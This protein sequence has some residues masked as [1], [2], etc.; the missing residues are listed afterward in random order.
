V[1][2]QFTDGDS[3]G[4][5]ST[6]VYLPKP[7]THGDIFLVFSHWD[8]TGITATISGGAGNTYVPLGPPIDIGTDAQGHPSWIQAWYAKIVSYTGS[9]TATYSATTDGFSLVDV[10]EYS[11]LDQ[12]APLDTASYA[13]NTGS[14]TS[15]LTTGASGTTTAQYET[16][17]GMFGVVDYG[18]YPFSPGSGF[19]E[20]LT[21]AS[22]YI[23][24][25]AATNT[26][27]YTAT[28]T[29]SGTKNYGAIIVG[30]KN[31]VQ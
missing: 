25:M 21:D 22:S 8:G 7:P 24:D 16:I 14:G 9:I 26:G 13:T 18:D 28:A 4:A 20:Q 11:G 12:T 23:E 3:N 30:F 17:V 19:S 27:S 2:F 10:I 15:A 29:A 31:A 1:V 5:A 6:I